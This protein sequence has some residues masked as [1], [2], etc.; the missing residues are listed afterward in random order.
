MFGPK[1]NRIAANDEDVTLMKAI[2]RVDRRSFMAAVNEAM[3]K[4]AGGS[5]ASI[6]VSIDDAGEVTLKPGE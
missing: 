3:S 1:F 2:G 6:K 4:A 5:T